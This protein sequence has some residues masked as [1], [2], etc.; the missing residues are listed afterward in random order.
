VTGTSFI[1]CQMMTTT[2]ISI[3]ALEEEKAA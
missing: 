2:L 1:V 3:A